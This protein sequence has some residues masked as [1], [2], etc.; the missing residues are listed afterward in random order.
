MKNIVICSDGTGNSAGKENGTNVF[1]LY[2]AVDLNGGPS[3]IPQVAVYDDGVGT[4]RLR[5]LQLLC[6]AVGLGLSRNVK[7]L[8]AS[9]VRS[10]D[11]GDRIYLFGF[12][13]GAFT[14]RTLA[15]M[16]TTCGILDRNKC[17]SDAEL[18]REVRECYRVYRS[19]Y[20]SVLGTI[21]SPR[22]PALMLTRLQERRMVCDARRAA[23]WQVPIEFIGVWDTVD[24]VGLPSDLLSAFINKFVY[25]F[26]F[27]DH[28][29]SPAVQHA[30]H[31]LAIDEERQTFQPLLW[32]EEGETS[33]RITQVWFPGVHSNVGGGYPKQGLSLVALHWM[34][35]QAETHGLRFVKSLRQEI[36]DCKNPNDKLYDSR[37]GFG[38]YYRYLP[39]D[40]GAICQ[41][42][43]TTVKLHWSA[44]ERILQGTDGYAPSSFPGQVQLVTT[45]TAPASLTQMNVTLNQALSETSSPLA[46]VQKRNKPHELARR[47]AHLA[48]VVTT[49]LAL[50]DAVTDAARSSNIVSAT[51]HVLSP[52]G[53]LDIARTLISHPLL[54][55]MLV[56]FYASSWIAKYCMDKNASEFW[57]R[58]LTRLKEC[59]QSLHSGPTVAPSHGKVVSLL[60]SLL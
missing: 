4:E 28:K 33:H 51:L 59:S 11:V 17:T 24:A 8:Y 58:H 3:V 42:A 34:M 46:Q 45:G 23:D 43:H 56:V 39:R 21:L 20:R 57:F 6:G 47:Y 32:S 15:G 27:P 12:S 40:L 44:L 25:R 60:R 54:P 49:V 50:Y 55:A 53:M 18:R 41:A 29:L 26:K 2:E 30:Y 37:A 14:V 5:P 16:I 36:S 52:D 10:Y 31:A 38:C 9:L 13:R 19:K 35:A 22:D 48:F 1:K 7:E